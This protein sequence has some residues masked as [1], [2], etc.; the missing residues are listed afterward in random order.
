M[1]CRQTIVVVS[2]KQLTY[3]SSQRFLPL[4]DELIITHLLKMIHSTLYPQICFALQ[5]SSLYIT[6]HGTNA[7]LIMMSDSNT[8]THS[9]PNNSARYL[10]PVSTARHRQRSLDGT[11]M[12][13]I[14][15]VYC[16]KNNRSRSTT[17]TLYNCFP[18]CPS[19]IVT[20]LKEGQVAKGLLLPLSQEQ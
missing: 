3:S 5:Y 4:A 13:N 10:C 14:Y 7:T 11:C 16:P 1:A 20:Y 18:T 2:I 19:S 6:I 9:I 8:G 12:K 15:A 17:S